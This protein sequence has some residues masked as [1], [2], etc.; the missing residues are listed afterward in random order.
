MSAAPDTEQKSGPSARAISPGGRLACSVHS[1]AVSEAP[2]A[3]ARR[4]VAG[5]VEA[6]ARNARIARVR[7]EKARHMAEVCERKA[8]HL[9]DRAPM[10]L[11][12]SRRLRTAA[13]GYDADAA[14]HDEA[15]HAA[16]GLPSIGAA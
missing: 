2:G 3:A 12:E 7:A 9:T 14:W 6:S 8:R 11:T 5:Y 15:A 1:P 10:Y 16:R 13:E 4:Q